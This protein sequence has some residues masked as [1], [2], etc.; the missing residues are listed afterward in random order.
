MLAG[1][2]H[3]T[4]FQWMIVGLLV[5]AYGTAA[6]TQSQQ[7]KPE[8]VR[9]QELIRQ[10]RIAAG[11]ETSEGGIQSLSFKAKTERF[12]KYFSVQ[13]PTKVVEND[14]TLGGKVEVEFSLP[15]KF[16]VKTKSDTLSGFDI[17]FT[18][19]LNGDLAWRDPPMT[20]RS[21]GPDRRVIDVGDVE[22]TMLM[23]TRT[24]K[25]RIA[26]YTLGWLLQTPPSVPVEMNYAGI[27]DLEG[28]KCDAVVVEGQEG[29][30][31]VLLFDQKTHLLTGM[32]IVFFDAIR[33]T[34][35]V[36]VA[37]F[38]RRYIR[39]TY[40]RARQERMARTK[41]GQQHEMLWHFLDHSS[42]G[43]VTL[44][45]RVKIT[46]DGS[47]IEEMTINEYRVNQP[48]NPRRFEGKPEVKY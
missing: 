36:E 32:G 33:E 31:N 17:S 35:I 47:A 24:A 37:G 4:W 39:D 28:R 46:L 29:L 41:P 44:P 19:A 7:P 34:V 38:D 13:S 18:E 48:I 23:Q 22:R 43:G 40:A 8:S 2:V 14:K 1:K 30:R 11:F 20:V 25:Q 6:A 42:V 12:V 16:R 9:V 5:L 26:F 27:V 3:T 10:A 15:D 21:F 45:H